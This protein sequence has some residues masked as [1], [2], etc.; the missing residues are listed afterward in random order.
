MQAVTTS[1]GGGGVFMDTLKGLGVLAQTE[2]YHSLWRGLTLTMWR[3]V[4]FSGVYWWGY[5]AVR[6]ALTEARDHRA[7]LRGISQEKQQGP[8]FVDS[9]LSGATSGAFAALIT[10]PFD[11]GKTRQQVLEREQACR[12]S[13]SS[14]SPPS[15]A[16][17][18]QLRPEEMSMPR[19]LYQIWLDEGVA[20][21]FR[22]WTARCLKVAPAC[23]IMISSYEVGKK[24]ARRMN[25]RKNHDDNKIER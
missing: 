17:K 25:E 23:A 21:L 22:G 18:A 15:G 12:S 8:A 3:D 1:R 7:G 13:K 4:P 20:G 6:N 16:G 14:S 19:F 10:T 11:V 24:M 5:E 2:G 9:F